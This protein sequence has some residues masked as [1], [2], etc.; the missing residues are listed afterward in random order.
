LNSL[1]LSKEILEESRGKGEKKKK[2]L[3]GL[4]MYDQRIPPLHYG[5]G[6]W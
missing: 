1:P 4:A 5:L 3:K 6:W 2:K